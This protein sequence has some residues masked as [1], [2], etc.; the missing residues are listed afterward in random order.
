MPRSARPWIRALAAAKLLVAGPAAAFEDAVPPF[1]L[2]YVCPEELYVF[3][4]LEHGDFDYCRLKLRYQPGSADC[5]RIVAPTCNVVT[6][7]QPARR[8]NGRSD[9]LLAGRAERIVCPPGPPPP[10]CPAGFR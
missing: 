5:L 10:T 9:W 7:G 6:P 3:S 2:P 4:S 1:V 8:F